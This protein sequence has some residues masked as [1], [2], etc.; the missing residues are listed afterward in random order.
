ME[1]GEP[2]EHG[3]VTR[4]IENAQKKVEEHNFD[5]RKHLLEYDDVMNKQR[6]VIYNQRREVLKAE[7]LKEQVLE[8]AE[9][10]T[11]EVVARYANKDDMGSG[12]DLAG[13]RE[14]INHQFNLRLDFKP[15][16]EETLTFDGIFDLVQQRL[17]TY[18]DKE[19][20]FTAPMLRQ[21]EKIIMRKPSTPCGKIC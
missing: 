20:R 7:S 19:Q 9:G 14:G 2:I 13:L 4:A 6:E 3:F 21:L 8:M 17:A 10:L 15:E 16:D 1:E 18:D 11:E 12:W 5:I